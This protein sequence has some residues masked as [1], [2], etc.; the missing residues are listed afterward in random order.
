MTTLTLDDDDDN[1]IKNKKRKEKSDVVLDYVPEWARLGKEPS[2]QDQTP[3]ERI[4]EETVVEKKKKE[5]PEQLKINIG[6]NSDWKSVSEEEKELTKEILVKDVPDPPKKEV[7]TNKSFFLS[8]GEYGV[9]VK[10]KLIKKS[11]SLEDCELVVQ[12]LL[13]NDELELTVDDIVL[14]KR[15]TLKFGVIAEK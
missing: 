14:I 15:F 12:Q 4:K 2:F 13:F 7:K 5:I 1:V 6:Q 10:N 8:G 3:D 9:I 11:S